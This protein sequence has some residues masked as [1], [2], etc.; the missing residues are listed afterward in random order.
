MSSRRESEFA[1]LEQ[2][3]Q[4]ADE[5]AEQ[6]RRRAEE[7]DKRAKDEQRIRQEAESRAQI[8]G[9]K[10]RPT[11]FEEYLR[12]CHTFLSKPLH[13]QTDKSLSTQGSITSPKNKLCPTL[14]KPWTDFP[15]L[16]Q[17]LFEQIY[18]YIPRDARLFSSTQYLTELG[19][20][21]CDRPLASEKDLEAYQRLAVER[22]ATHI[23]SQLQRIEEARNAFDLGEG[24]IFEN[25]ANTLSDSNEE[26][27]ES[28]Q[29]LRISSKGHDSSSNPK[30]RN[31]D[32]I[33][34]YKEADGTRSLCMVVEYK[35]SHKLSVFNL[36]AGLL[37]AD[38]GSMNIPE[39]VINRIT[40]PTDLDDKFVYH[41]EWLT[42]AALTQTYTYMI[43]NGLEFSKLLT[44]E[45]DIFLRLKEDEPYTLYYH[46]AE[47]NIEAEAQSEVDILLCRTAVSQT[48][49]FCLMA[50]D[51]KPRNQ[52]WRNHA[53]ETAYRAVIDHEAILRQIPAEEKT[54]T[55]PSSVFHARTHPFKRSPIMLRPRK[56]RKVRNS[57][58]STDIIVH[59]DPQSPSSSSDETSD[60]ETP[61]KQRVRTRQSG[62]GQTRSAKSSQAAEQSDVR[63]RQYC[64][65]A[66]L[67][68]LARK[69]PLDDACPNV[70][71][72]RAHGAGNY[73]A[74]RR[75]S[76]AKLILRQLAEDPDNGCEPLGKQGARGALFRLT[77][78]RY[79]Y[80][81][82]AKGTVTAFKAKLKHEGLV[83]RH[84]GEVQGSITPVYLGN[85]SLVR[86][87]FLDFG[88]RIVHMMLM[89]WG[90]MQARSDLMSA[91]GR[92]L[93]VETSKAVTRL[94][95]CGVEHRDVRPPNVLWNPETRNV[96]LVDFER[97]EILKQVPVLQETSP[98]RKRKHLHP[99]ASCR[100]LSDGHFI[101]P[102]KCFDW[103]D[104]YL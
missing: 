75:K 89:S 56:S 61:S 39:D 12:A 65:Q 70:K 62:T 17:Q 3:L 63:H 23:I 11:T 28:L 58:G 46:L 83:Y 92:D 64:T 36:R 88:V 78:E 49:T 100:S 8:E 57:C 9:E 16:Q 6:E 86:P 76:L 74:L 77:L 96:M 98:N 52:N 2:L 53:V 32:Q 97:S 84:A 47:P 67:L 72:H 73:H 69:R 99:E 25:H 60:V 29:D 48:L 41:S 15:V 1:R 93:A 51:S 24:I 7:A 79:G 5:R 50:L 35:P 102:T 38:K 81:F 59:E 43:E 40:I 27:R 80:T 94:R 45:A 91:I 30:P 18:E 13:I 101:N 103:N 22:P 95:D 20:D 66:C 71:A 34:V 10:T 44:G 104:P 85:I 90:G 19:Q 4:E 26:V 87:Y 55:P 33:C 37:R 82:V 42:T 68:G 21:I 31:A 14:L 54:L